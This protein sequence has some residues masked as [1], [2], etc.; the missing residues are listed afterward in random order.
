MT[1]F[2]IEIIRCALAIRGSSLSVSYDNVFF[3][4]TFYKRQ[5][6]NLH[7]LILTRSVRSTIFPFRSD[8]SVKKA[9]FLY[10]TPHNIYCTTLFSYTSELELWF[11]KLI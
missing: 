6:Y 3:N 10:R 2:K 7:T 11:Q 1:G 4:Y 5:Y 8:F 9:I